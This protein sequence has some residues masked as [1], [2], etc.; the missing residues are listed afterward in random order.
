MTPFFSPGPS[1]YPHPEVFTAAVNGYNCLVA[2]EVSDG[3][4]LHSLVSPEYVRQVVYAQ[5]RRGRAP[6]RSQR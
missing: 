1:E 6:R 2:G 5:R 4:M 3:L